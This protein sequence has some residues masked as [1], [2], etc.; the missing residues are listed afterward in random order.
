MRA[1]ASRCGLE[2]FYPR[3]LRGGRPHPAVFP[4]HCQVI[5]IHALCEEG[6]KVAL[7]PKKGLCY[8]Y[9]RP[10]RGGR[11]RPGRLTW[12]FSIFLSTPSARRA[13]PGNGR[14]LPRPLISIHALCEEGDHRR[15][16]YR[17]RMQNFYPRPLRGGR[18]D[19][20]MQGQKHRV[21]FYPRPLR[22]GRLEYNHRREVLKI[23]L[24]TPSARRATSCCK[25]LRLWTCISIHALCEEG[26]LRPQLAMPLPFLISIHA[27]CEEGDPTSRDS[28]G[29]GVI[30]I[31]ALCEE[32]DAYTTTSNSKQPYF[33][34][35]PLRGGRPPKV[36]YPICIS[37]ISIHALCEEGDWV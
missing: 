33:Y 19:K 13:T 9:P 23:F 28:S 31:H 8:F 25:F 11:R 30:S 20:S 22:G 5:S 14:L 10:L 32:G 36:L 26:D 18:P 27:L 29:C 6:D 2:N 12:W 7:P 1:T 24:S 4:G 37:I 35:R 16:E 15:G 34:P 3:P 21:Y 17:G